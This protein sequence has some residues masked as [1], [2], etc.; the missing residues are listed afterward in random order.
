LVLGKLFKGL[1]LFLFMEKEPVVKKAVQKV[2]YEDVSK[3]SIGE[4]VAKNFPEQLIPT[5]RINAIFGI[6]F[7]AVIMIAGFQFPFTQFLSGN[8]EVVINLGYPWSFLALDLSAKEGPNLQLM[9]LFLDLLLYLILAYG[10]DIALNLILKTFKSEE[11][12]RKIPTVFK[13]RPQSV[14]EKV[15]EKVFEDPIKQKPVK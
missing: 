10:I 13:D 2:G 6:V 4:V 12:I 9:N 1:M 7:L 15:T 8:A 14:A 3:G 11:E 5:K